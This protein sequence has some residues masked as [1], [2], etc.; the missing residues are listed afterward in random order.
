MENKTHPSVK[1]PTGQH[2][3]QRGG[4]PQSRD[5]PAGL[6]ALPCD[7]CDRCDHRWAGTALGTRGQALTQPAAPGQLTGLTSSC[8]VETVQTQ[9]KA[10]SEMP[11]T[12]DPELWFG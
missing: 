12:M 5:R 4:W 6:V 7:H 9:G 8:L 3:S 2:N 11:V 10:R 1:T